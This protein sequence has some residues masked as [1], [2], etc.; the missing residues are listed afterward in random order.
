MFSSFFL[1]LSNNIHSSTK[2]QTLSRFFKFTV[3]INQ[4]CCCFVLFCFFSSTLQSL[5]YGGG[6]CQSAAAP[7]RHHTR[8]LTRSLTFIH[9]FEALRA[10]GKVCGEPQGQYRSAAHY[11]RR[12]HE[13]GQPEKQTNKQ[14]GKKR[15]CSKLNDDKASP[16]S[17][18]DRSLA[19][20]RKQDC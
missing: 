1:F 17:N 16:T 10:D 7:F 4:I 8:S 18:I 6:N 20:A 2:S 11:R 12:Q 19:H 5:F 13:S 14:G 9:G 15:T 3:T